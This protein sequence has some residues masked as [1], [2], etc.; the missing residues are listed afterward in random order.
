[1]RKSC[2]EVVRSSLKFLS[3]LYRNLYSRYFR[4]TSN[5]TNMAINDSVRRAL[6]GKN[7]IDEVRI[8]NTNMQKKFYV[9]INLSPVRLKILQPNPIPSRTVIRRSIPEGKFGATI[10]GKLIELMPHSLRNQII[11]LWFN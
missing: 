11:L 6:I 10:H 7:T 1:M 8:N 4:C 2:L 5:S 3:R 9:I